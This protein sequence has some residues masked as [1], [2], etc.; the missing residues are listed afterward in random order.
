MPLPAAALLRYR[1]N[2]AL[3]LAL[4]LGGLALLS[5]VFML[6]NSVDPTRAIDLIDL[7]IS[8]I[9]REPRIGAAR[10]AGVTAAE[11]EITLLA[12]SVRSPTDPQGNAPI[13]LFL[14]HPDGTT[15]FTDGSY[16]EFAS[17]AGQIDELAQLLTMEDSVSLRSSNGYEL[18]MAR[19][20]GQLDLTRFEGTGEVF[21][22]GPAGEIQADKLVVTPIADE[23]GG[24]LLDF[25][26]DVRLIYQPQH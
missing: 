13:Q 21:G 19:L 20:V 15:R 9:A 2:R 1:L 3:R 10:L 23:Q 24:Y 5:T 6:S 18:T 11:A 12:R 16:I 17:N 7:D 26:G 22:H 25:T 4:P 8:D 14:D